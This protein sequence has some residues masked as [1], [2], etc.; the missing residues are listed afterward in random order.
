MRK[1][2]F[3]FL[4]DERPPLIVKILNGENIL[5]GQLIPVAAVEDIAAKGIADRLAEGVRHGIGQQT[6]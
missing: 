6:G 2:L 1:G 4:F 3:P 5:P